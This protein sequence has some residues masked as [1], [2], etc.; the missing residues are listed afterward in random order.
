[1]KKFSMIASVLVA[2]AIVV[3]ALELPLQVKN[4]ELPFLT[5]QAK[6]PHDVK[7]AIKSSLNNAKRAVGLL[8]KPEAV[9]FSGTELQTPPGG[10]ETEFY[11][12]KGYTEIANW[13]DGDYS[14]LVAIDGNTMWVKNL[15]WYATDVWVKG[16]I[17]G[18]Q[19]VFEKGQ[20]M[21]PG[22]GAW[23]TPFEHTYLAAWDGSNNVV[24]LTFDWDAEA[25]KLYLNNLSFGGACGANGEPVEQVDG[26]AEWKTHGWTLQGTGTAGPKTGGDD[27]DPEGDDKPT[28]AD[29]TPVP[30]DFD[31]TTEEGL[32]PF[33]IVDAN[34]DGTTWKWAS[35]SNCAWYYC[36]DKNNANDWLITPAVLLE[37]GKTYRMVVNTS[38]Q[39]R[40]YPERMELAYGVAATAPAMKK[41]IL[42]PLVVNFNVAT[43]V[44]SNLFNIKETGD[45]YLGVHCISDK[46]MY[47]LR[48]YNIS[49]V[50]VQ[51]AGIP[52]AVSNLH[53]QPNAMGELEGEVTFNL[54]TTF[55]NDDP[56]PATKTLEYSV[57]RNGTEIKTGTGAAGELVKFMDYVDESAA[58][59]YSVVVRNGELESLPAEYKTNIG[60]D[61]PG[62]PSNLKH[63]FLYPGM[64]FTW[65]PVGTVGE[66]GGYVD[67]LKCTYRLY[68]L[69]VNGGQLY[70]D[71]LLNDPTTPNLTTCTFRWNDFEVGD[72]YR[73]YY[74]VF[75]VNEAG[76]GYATINSF[77]G[78]AKYELPYTEGFADATPHYFWDFM[79]DDSENAK[80][81]ITY[82]V[83]TDDD[84]YCY[85]SS[86]TVDENYIIMNS[87]KISLQGAANPTLTFDARA[88]PSSS[89]VSVK[90]DGNNGIVVYGYKAD[91]TA[92]VLLSK[93]LTT[94]FEKFTV[95]LK[96]Y[97][98]TDYLYLEFYSVFNKAGQIQMDNISIYDKV[99]NA[100]SATVETP[101]TMY[102]G[103]IAPI[104][105]AVTNEGMNDIN[106][107]TLI[108][109]V[110][111]EEFVSKT[112][113]KT[114][115]F[116]KSN[117]T[118]DYYSTTL[119][120]E[121]GDKKVSVDIVT[122]GGATTH[123]DTT[124]TVLAPVV[125]QPVNVD[126]EFTTESTI[127]VSWNAPEAP[128]APVTEE[129]EDYNKWSTQFGEWTCI[130]G[131]DAYSQQVFNVE[132]PVDGTQY[133]F[134][135]Y[136][137]N[138]L[139]QT[140][141]FAGHSG[142][143]FIG[144]TLGTTSAT[145]GAYYEYVTDWLVSPELP[146]IAQTV[147]FWIKD[148][149]EYPTHWKGYYSTGGKSIND[150][151]ECTQ[152]MTAGFDEWTPK[153][154][155]IPEGA[156]YFAIRRSQTENSPGLFI[157]LDDISYVGIN[158]EIDSYNI[159]V[160]GEYYTTVTTTSAD[161]T[162]MT[163][164]DHEVAVSTVYTD[165]SESIPVIITV[166]AISTGVIDLNAQGR[167]VQAVFNAAG[168]QINKLQPGVN[169]IRYTDGSTTKIFK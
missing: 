5:E 45:Y 63:T 14:P 42:D 52:A 99:D 84:N 153:S 25:K 38:C 28:S 167:Q 146:G 49:V 76:E 145:G 19:V 152:S 1:M 93:A 26:D 166:E 6:M 126:G 55:S 100:V 168:Q 147:S 87:G 9:S 157:F 132:S 156:K 142:E 80:V 62:K 11:S 20:Y 128:M 81:D 32:A 24:D 86:S 64:R 72:Q 21:G 109:T 105:V 48:V 57:S 110:D 96:N 31:L 138:D 34:N 4:L 162:E 51:V 56:I 16:T 44:E 161:L 116:H 10:L 136:N 108:I 139:L 89:N 85:T 74:S 151:I 60:V 13:G 90:A 18:N 23:N 59:T 15:V 66:G 140:T 169:I 71:V 53:V 106:N 159:Y 121:L 101:S 141:G 135:V 107:Y 46:D 102:A 125:S 77:F 37:A 29:G 94:S 137:L 165:G 75:A 3:S 158:G 131:D 122:D 133:A 97:R 127:S 17:T 112:V 144:N 111:G 7:T 154:F 30:A 22:T 104:S 123:C 43:D 149:F 58:Y 35:G 41:N 36:S 160:D 33:T 61:V 8:A 88:L 39:V 124:I 119:F 117:T 69:Y 12:V 163:F 98:K 115:A 40:S 70:R 68:T 155:D 120:D 134:A 65:D 164:E 129:F 148:S 27:P 91:G 118:V 143:Q 54:P 73:Q 2:C 114:L 150:F 50:E 47:A 83:S 130:N 92:E 79:A 113:N 103:D 78:G 67:P 82:G 95:D